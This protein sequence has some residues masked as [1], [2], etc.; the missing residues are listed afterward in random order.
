MK[1]NRK[2]TTKFEWSKAKKV[3]VKCQF[4]AWHDKEIF[5][6]WIDEVL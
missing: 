5:S 1:D 4:E 6:S 2:K 3:I